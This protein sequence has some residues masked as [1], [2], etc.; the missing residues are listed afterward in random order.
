[1]ALRPEITQTIRMCRH[2]FM[3]R[4]ANPTFL[5]TKL[6]GHTPRGYALALSRIEDGLA[7][8][9]E[10]L[11]TKLYQSTMDGLC[12]ELCEFGWRE[13]L[14]VQA[15]RGEAIQAGMAPATVERAARA[16]G[17]DGTTAGPDVRTS[18]LEAVPG[19]PPSRLDRE[20]A[21]VLFLTGLDARLRAPRTVS[22]SAAVLEHLG[23]DWT[24]L[25]EERDP[26]I[27]LWELGY[28]DAA[29]EAA[30]RFAADMTRWQPASIVT[31]SSR[32]LRA[33]RELLPAWQVA[34][35]PAARHISEFLLAELG[36]SWH[37]VARADP[38][39][40]SGAEVVAY[41]DPCALGRRLA[42]LDPPRQLIA[43]LT[44]APP[45]ELF[46][47][48][49]AAECCGGGGLLPEVDPGLSGR[50]ARARLDR[51][52][53]GVTTVVTACPTCRSALGAAAEAEGRDLEVLEISEFVAARLGIR[54]EA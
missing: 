20:A 44:G 38:D 46:H 19:V 43:S 17:L 40:R 16:R 25:T 9:T 10:D 37:G 12:A 54:A 51:L 14:V 32:V 27:D 28:T 11:A 24:M 15:G 42:V 4:H 48:G 1:M 39:D 8:W 53:E 49:K 7:G 36:I 50:M 35:L 2:C 33:I 23:C 5:V 29:R 18:G 31:G 30:G 41:H 3:C 21:D 22:T 26:G 52:P 47:T 6:D 13:D 34:Q 45:A